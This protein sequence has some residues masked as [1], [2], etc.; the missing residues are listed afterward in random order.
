MSLNNLLGSK[1]VRSLLLGTISGIAFMA[2]LAPAQAHNMFD[3][4]MFYDE[5]RYRRAADELEALIS[6]RKD[7]ADTHYLLGNTYVCL[8]LFPEA[9]HEYALALTRNPVPKVKQHCLSAI[10]S[11]HS[12]ADLPMAPPPLQ[13]TAIA[14]MKTAAADPSLPQKSALMSRV[15]IAAQQ[16]QARREDNLQKQK[17]AILAD[18]EKRAEVV[19]QES[20]ARLAEYKDAHGQYWKENGTGRLV[21]ELDPA[22]ERAF[23]E[24]YEAEISHILADG[25]RRADGLGGAST[26]GDVTASINRQVYSS[27]KGPQLDAAQSNLYTR[28]YNINS[29]AK[30]DGKLM[31]G[32]DKIVPH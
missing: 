2:S 16:D 18:A 31:A 8:K 3:A 22:L 17:A 10:A 21:W 1:I 25:Q 23:M 32:K 19:R 5:G 7:T 15:E 30:L 29:P 14:A 26:L 28:T 20:R 4:R 27:G 9:K 6:E 24:P 13:R 12:V 11:L